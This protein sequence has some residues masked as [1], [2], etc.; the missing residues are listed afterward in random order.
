MRLQPKLLVFGN[1]YP[2]RDG[3]GERDYIHVSDLAV[4]YVD[5]VHEMQNLNQFEVLNFG[6]GCS[7]NVLELVRTFEKVNKVIIPIEILPRRD[8]D[9]AI[10]FTDTN[11]A[12]KFLNFKCTKSINDMCRVA[13]RWYGNEN[14]KI[15]NYTLPKIIKSS[16]VNT[17]I[18]SLGIL[19]GL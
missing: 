2:I 12:K 5:A 9:F 15:K 18:A 11:R 7:T 14:L 4:G 8:G 16:R 3:T 10:S 19:L 13:W 6:T 1:D 17:G